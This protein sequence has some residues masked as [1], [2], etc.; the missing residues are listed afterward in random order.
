[1]SN[2][3]ES[4]LAR[5]ILQSN[6]YGITALTKMEEIKC[7]LY[8]DLGYQHIHHLLRANDIDAL[9][10]LPSNVDIKKDL[11]TIVKI[12]AGDGREFFV[13]EYDPFD[14]WMDAEIICYY[15]IEHS[16]A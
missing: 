3:M 13:T 5:T 11:L 14:L 2:L 4:S 6:S 1:M 7:C 10:A 9:W 12:T 15:P 8:D 16:S